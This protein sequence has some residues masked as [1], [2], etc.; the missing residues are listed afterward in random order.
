MVGL[1]DLGPIAA[2]VPESAPKT[3]AVHNDDEE[4][5]I[6]CAFRGALGGA[7]SAKPKAKASAKAKQ[8]RGRPQHGSPESER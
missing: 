1:T 5:E 8:Q 3:L 4:D 6:G 2:W 7:V